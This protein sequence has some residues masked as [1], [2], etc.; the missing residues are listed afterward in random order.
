MSILVTARWR[1]PASLQLANALQYVN[2]ARDESEHARHHHDKGEGKKAQ[3]QHHPRDRAH[4]ANG[5]D[6]SGPARF[7]FHFVADEI[8]ENDRAD[9]DDRVAGNDED[10]KPN[11]KFSVVGIGFAPVADAESNNATQEQAFVRDWIENCAEGA[12]LFVA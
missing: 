1:L 12:A 2:D 5:G 6:F 11:R 8:M 3:L 7:H 10:R 4:L 9:Q